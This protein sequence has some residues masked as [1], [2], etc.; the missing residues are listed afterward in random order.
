MVNTKNGAESVDLPC[1]E[2]PHNA[3]AILWSRVKEDKIV[4]KFYLNKRG[5]YSVY[6]T[7]NKYDLNESL[8][9][10]LV[11]KNIE[12]SDTGYY[13][14]QTIGLPVFFLHTTWL[15]VIGKS[16]ITC[17]LYG[18]P[19]S[20]PHKNIFEYAYG[21]HTGLGV[22]KSILVTVSLIICVVSTTFTCF[23]PVVCNFLLLA[24]HLYYP[25]PQLFMS[26]STNVI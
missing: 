5:R 7:P 19:S 26:L 13:T 10:C 6:Y 3:P 11:I 4:Q 24:P 23:P 22:I 16:L 15:R 12:P 8:P 1:G 9:G 20:I 21:R 25:F 14:C 17:L 18:K 2:V